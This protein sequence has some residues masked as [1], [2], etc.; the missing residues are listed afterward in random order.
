MRGLRGATHKLYAVTEAWVGGVGGG[1]TH[2]DAR[3]KVYAENVFTCFSSL[4]MSSRQV[5]V[6]EW[7]SGG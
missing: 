6:V 1:D 3:L 7:G 4:F 5:E 2:C